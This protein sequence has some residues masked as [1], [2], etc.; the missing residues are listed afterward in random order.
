MGDYE[1][2]QLQWL[3]DHEYSLK[4]LMTE[5]TRLQYEDP[6][7]TERI[8]TPIDQLF[9]EWEADVGFD[10]EIWACKEEWRDCE[11]TEAI[12]ERNKAYRT[13]AKHLFRAHL[14]YEGNRTL[15]ILADNI[16]EATEKAIAAFGLN[17]VHVKRINPTEDPQVYEI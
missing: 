3:I 4:D 16:E 12:S 5:L 15:I 10:S 6:E 11:L 17:G 7:A 2:Y 1:K 8:T 14:K 13:I 9:A